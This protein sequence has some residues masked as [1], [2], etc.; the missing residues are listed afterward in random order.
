VPR[1][2]QNA[3]QLWLEVPDLLVAVLPLAL[4][5]LLLI[6]GFTP[7]LKTLSDPNTSWTGFPYQA[8]VNRLSSYALAAQ[9]PGTPPA[10]LVRLREEALSS[11][12]NRGEYVD[13][14]AVEAIGAAR[15]S[16][17]EALFTA[18]IP[19]QQARLS[20]IQEAARLNGQAHE[21]V[22][23]V[24]RKH[25]SQLE[26]L[27][28]V[29]L[30]AAALSG[31]LSAALILRS[32]RLWRNEKRALDNQRE[33]LSLASHEL[34]RPLQ[35]LLL[36]TDLL[37]SAGSPEDRLL[38]LGVV[39]NSAAQLA[40]RADLG[41]LE[42][43]YGPVSARSEGAQSQ[44]ANDSTSGS[45]GPAQSGPAYSGPV[46]DWQRLDLAALLSGFEGARTQLQVPARPVWV[47]GDPARLRQI[48]E[49]LHENAL[50]YSAGPVLLRLD[51][52]GQRPELRVQDSGPGI[53]PGDVER[54][55]LPRERGAQVQQV[56]GSGLG[57][58]IARRLAQAHG[59]DL[60]L[61]SASGSG[62]IAVLRLA[63]QLAEEPV[64][65]RDQG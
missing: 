21:R 41:Q 38:Y 27:Q 43:L 12:R 10:T 40:S 5:V 35:A 57:L 61:E 13:L 3:R 7:I 17:V 19:G 42:A 52:S 56:P 15:L 2:S 65:S 39:E 45:G 49:N 20:A 14:N 31:L 55:F 46:L 58:T 50:R 26:R 33:L 34:R 51:V 54:L 60:T 9:T 30:L 59:A 24:Q 28:L 32:L 48:I 37:R 1:P 63:P 11:L 8:L 22:H 44:G 62:T 4:T 25:A 18:Q 6:S 64:Q 16:R 47:R 29:L 23:Q 53:D 36:A